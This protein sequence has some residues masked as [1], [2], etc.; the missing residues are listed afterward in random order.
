MTGMAAGSLSRGP[1]RRVAKFLSLQ[2]RISA[3][4]REVIRQPDPLSPH[5]KKRRR[6]PAAASKG[7]AGSLI[8]RAS[9]NA[10]TFRPTSLLRVRA[11]LP[12]Y[13]SWAGAKNGSYACAQMPS[14]QRER[15]R[16][17]ARYCR[18]EPAMDWYGSFVSRWTGRCWKCRHGLP[19]TA[20]PLPSKPP[21]GTDRF[22]DG[23]AAL[24]R[25]QVAYRCQRW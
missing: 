19:T 21:L 8:A 5:R 22:P 4:S 10:A 25:P 9:A 11:C 6:P 17:D 23:G 1:M 12:R 3:S 14:A 16:P 18:L 13:R 24:C 20:T 15:L 2:L 7:K